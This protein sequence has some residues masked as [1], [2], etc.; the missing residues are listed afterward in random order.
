MNKLYY[1]IT[2][3]GIDISIGLLFITDCPVSSRLVR[4]YLLFLILLPL[5][6][7]LRV[8][9]KIIAKNSIVKDCKYMM[10]IQDKIPFSEAAPYTRRSQENLV[11]SP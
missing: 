8:I 5:F 1:E 6:F 9:M 7:Y 3:L 11:A 10:G 2:D 4:H